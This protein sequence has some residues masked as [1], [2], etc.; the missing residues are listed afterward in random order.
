MRRG[1]TVMRL[2]KADLPVREGFGCGVMINRGHGGVVYKRMLMLCNSHTC[3][4]ELPAS[5][6]SSSSFLSFFFSIAV[7][8]YAPLVLL[9]YW[10]AT[11]RM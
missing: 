6:S 11:C 8:D 5:P 4:C 1:S 7:T 3:C 2:R 10:I 9:F